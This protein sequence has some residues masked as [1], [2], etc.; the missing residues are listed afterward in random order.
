M[1]V[2]V[3]GRVGL[4]MGRGMG[5]GGRGGR[6]CGF[7]EFIDFTILESDWLFG[8]LKRTPY[9]DV[10]LVGLNCWIDWMEDA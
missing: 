4:G 5:K 8:D 10:V 3:G 6:L 9:L 7:D 1:G 2:G